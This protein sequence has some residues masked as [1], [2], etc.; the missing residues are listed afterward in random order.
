MKA[1]HFSLGNVFFICT[2]LLWI[3]TV[4]SVYQS[5]TYETCYASNVINNM[6][7]HATVVPDSTLCLACSATVGNESPWLQIDFGTKAMMRT[8]RIFGRDYDTP[9]QS[10]NLL[11]SISNT[12]HFV[13]Q[14]FSTWEDFGLINAS[15]P[16][17]GVMWDLGVNRVLQYLVFRRPLPSVMA[18]CEV[19]VFNTDCEKGFFG[20][21][22][23]SMCQCKDEQPCDSVT[24]KCATPGC[25]AGWKGDSCSTECS[26][27]EFGVDCAS[28]CNCYDNGV[29]DSIDGK[30][31]AGECAPGWQGNTCDIECKSPHFGQNCSQTCHCYLSGPC[32][33]INGLCTH[34]MCAP[35]WLGDSCDKVRNLFAT[36]VRHHVLRTTKIVYNVTM[37]DLGKAAVIH[38]IATTAHRAI[39]QM[40]YVPITYVKRDGRETVVVKAQGGAVQ[41][42]NMRM[43]ARKEY[44]VLDTLDKI[45]ARYATAMTMRPVFHSAVCV[46][47]R[48]V[49]TAGKDQNV[50]MV[51][52][53]KA[54]VIYAI[55]TTAHRAITQMAYVPI[56]Y[57]K[58]DGRE[59][60]VV[61]V[62][63]LPC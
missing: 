9:G 6:T 27:D 18:I 35:G 39:T 17:N 44:V 59:T 52:L 51:H 41:T 60:A 11:V 43:Y 46:R 4:S 2:C 21:K 31:I 57:V 25:F 58:R 53:G 36:N 28:T 15:D 26:G 42:Q 54:A 47:I 14:N 29:C 20:D 49:L 22:C 19:A 5:S 1:E 13:N 48:S 50:P 30:C 10:S 12:S 37:V 34:G 61:K 38:A 32:D 63:L 62:V 55:A 8:L 7:L 24:G 16:Y 40:A 23:A 33:P 56:T 45:V 3:I